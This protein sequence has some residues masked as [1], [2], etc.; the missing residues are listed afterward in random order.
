MIWSW[1]GF[2]FDVIFAAFFALVVGLPFALTSPTHLEAIPI[3]WVIIAAMLI[4]TGVVGRWEH[5]KK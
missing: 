2:W 4:G 5:L 1:F 3:V